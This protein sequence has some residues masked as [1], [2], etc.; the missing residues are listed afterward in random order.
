MEIIELAQNVAPAE[1]RNR[2]LPRVTTDYFWIVDAD[3]VPATD[4]LAKL[5]A[6]LSTDAT[7]GIV[8]GPNPQDPRKV[9]YAAAAFD[10]SNRYLVDPAAPP[11]DVPY[12]VGANMLVRRAVIE[13]VGYYD[14]NLRIAEDFDLAR[15][16]APGWVARLVRAKGAFG[17][18]PPPLHGL[19]LFALPVHDW[20]LWLP[21][22][23]EAPRRGPIR[24]L[25][26]NHTCTGRVARPGV[27]RD[28]ARS[29]C[30]K[31][32][33]G[34]SDPP[35]HLVFPA[36]R[37]RPMLGHRRRNP[38]ARRCEESM[39]LTSPRHSERFARGMPSRS[40]LLS[41]VRINKPRGEPLGVSGRDPAENDDSGCT[42]EST[43][44]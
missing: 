10:F 24:P 8:G 1:A 36:Y 26:S 16:G 28:G 30:G 31:E 2:A 32:R 14:P 22:S 43:V 12:V 11:T 25:V 40:A 5:C 17:A 13:Q 35:A 20:P 19:Q 42:Q 7:I 38:G 18:S 34:R 3:C 33:C 23:C 39:I 4:C 37:A 44:L 21:V 41:A 15:A 9:T 29:D 27:R 6:L